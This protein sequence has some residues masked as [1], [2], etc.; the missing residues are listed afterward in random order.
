LE[1]II[2]RS[3]ILG[4]LLYHIFALVLILTSKRHF[5]RKISQK[6]FVPIRKQKNGYIFILE[7]PIFFLD[8]LFGNLLEAK[9]NS[10]VTALIEV[11][12]VF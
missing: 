9:S 11:H 2:L 5:S 7:T 3:G 12:L 1:Q 6:R 8:I 10:F 4:A